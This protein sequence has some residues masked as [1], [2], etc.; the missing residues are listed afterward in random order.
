MYQE[1]ERLKLHKYK[2][3][4]KMLNYQVTITTPMLDYG[5]ER[6]GCRFIPVLL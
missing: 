6:A 3:L 2:V 5:E 1:C 4:Q